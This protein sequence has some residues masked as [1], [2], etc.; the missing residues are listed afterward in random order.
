MYKRGRLRISR[1]RHPQNIQYMHLAKICTYTVSAFGRLHFT[2]LATYCKPIL[3]LYVHL[4]NYCATQ[5]SICKLYMHPGENK[6]R[7][8]IANRCI[9]Y[10][11]YLSY[12]VCI[13]LGACELQLSCIMDMDSATVNIMVQPH[14]ITYLGCLTTCYKCW[15]IAHGCLCKCYTHIE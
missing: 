15:L 8:G 1:Q 13:L 14:R 9:S 6:G 12:A 7:D 5:Y 11:W 3:V 10:L 2:G 4:F